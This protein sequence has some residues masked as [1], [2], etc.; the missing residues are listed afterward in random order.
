MTK[1][2]LLNFLYMIE[3]DVDF[4]NSAGSYCNPSWVFVGCCVHWCDHSLVPVWSLAAWPVCGGRECGRGAHASPRCACLAEVCTPG[5]GVHAWRRCAC[6]A[7]VCT[8]GGGV[9]AWW[10]CARLAEVAPYFLVVSVIQVCIFYAVFVVSI[11]S[12]Y[13]LT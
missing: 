10:R 13:F 5:G 9:H 4:V 2:N 3:Y 11:I 1:Q 8:P 12:D 7:E 6:L